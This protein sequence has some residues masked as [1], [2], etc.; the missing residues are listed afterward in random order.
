MGSELR[1]P[2]LHS[3][4]VPENS[5][6]TGKCSVASQVSVIKIMLY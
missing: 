6:H 3:R 2:A 1:L 5:M 4:T